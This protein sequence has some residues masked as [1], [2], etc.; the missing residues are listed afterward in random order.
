[1]DPAYASTPLAHKL[2]GPSLFPDRALPTALTDFVGREL[3][4][5]RVNTLLDRSRLVSLVGPGGIG[6]TRLALQIAR[7]R[8]DDFA[9]GVRFVSLASTMDPSLVPSAIASSLGI[10][11]SPGKSLRESLV[12]GLRDKETLLVLDNFEQVVGAAPL[13]SDL[14][15]EAARIRVLVTSREPLRV[16]GEHVYPVPPLPLPDSA[17][18]G[19]I[20]DALRSPAVALFVLRAQAAS[21]EFTL[22]PDNAR[23]VVELCRRLDGLPLAIEIA[24]A[25]VDRVEPRQMLDSNGLLLATEGPRD[26]PQRH[27]TLNNVVD[28]SYSMLERPAQLVFGRLAVFASGASAEAA[29]AVCDGEELEGKLGRVLGSLADKSLVVAE[30][31][32][33]GETR[34]VMLA[35]M[36]SFAAEKLRQSGDEA[37]AKGRH[38]AHFAKLGEQLAASL[39]TAQQRATL[40]RFEREY[41]NFQAALAHLRSTAPDAAAT[42]ALS[43]G[44]FWEKRGHWAEGF[45]WLDALSSAKGLDA[46]LRA[47]CLHFA[48]RLAR[49]QSD[50]DGAVSRLHEAE[51]MAEARGDAGLLAM[52]Y[53]DL[54]CAALALRSDYAHARKMLGQSVALFRKVRD[55]LGAAE[56][57]GKLGL[58]AYYQADHDGAERLCNEAL[59]LAKRH[60]D[61]GAASAVVNVLGLVARARGDYATAATLLEEHLRTCEWLDD[62]YGMMD[63]LFSLAEFARSRGDLDKASATYQ[64]YIALCR[65]VGNAGGTAIA[66]NDLGEV[67][68]Y[69]GRFDEAAALY[70]R[71]LRLLEVTGYVGDIPWVQRNQAEIAM[72]RGQLREARRLYCES[73][74]HHRG[75]THPMLLLLCVEGLAAIDA[76]EGRVDRAAQLVGAAERLFEADGA[77]LAVGDRDDYMRR[78]ALVKERLDERAYDVGRAAGRQ[79]ASAQVVALAC[80][81]I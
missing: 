42:L 54:G 68:R 31:P 38:A 41:P 47:R 49:H 65:E 20:D 6:K 23:D 73:L 66:V 5:A 10:R 69:S 63:A 51:A 46:A 81:P 30:T 3:E 39:G 18:A 33:G 62:K 28:W 74:E 60:A 71:A 17:A 29:A 52:V 64:K 7:G 2:R 4:Q 48:G 58:L 50:H 27:Q 56:A 34:H 53:Y 75:D 32:E 21:F 15:T 22:K 67:A 40:D 43:L 37:R 78:V 61:P 79:L 25:R 26:L 11:Q 59:A 16:S 35:T 13:V 45:D 76:L 9:D 77:L 55:E 8:A 80:E 70:E 44:R 57:L 19:S 36:R 12:A 72:H 14:L 24:A 1:V